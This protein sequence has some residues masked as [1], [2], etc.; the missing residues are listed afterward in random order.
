M[1]QYDAH[2]R[3]ISGWPL[4]EVRQLSDAVMVNI[5]GQHMAQSEKLISQKPDWQF[6]YY[7]KNQVK[8]NRKMG[9]ITITTTDIE[10]T[11]VEIN[12]TKVWDQD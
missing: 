9:H 12:E 5:L 1:S 4:G 2:I 3:G 11:L 7:G 8:R 6:H 10:K